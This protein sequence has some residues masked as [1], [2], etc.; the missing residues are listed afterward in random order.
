MSGRGAGREG[1]LPIIASSITKKYR[2]G[3][4]YP[5][6]GGLDAGGGLAL[7]VPALPAEL[8]GIGETVVLPYQGERGRSRAHHTIAGMTPLSTTSK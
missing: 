8:D 4:T 2:S 1:V 7:S 3:S 5:V 6:S